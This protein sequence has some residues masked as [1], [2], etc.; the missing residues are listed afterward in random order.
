M[1]MT[2]E[3]KNSSF[4]TLCLVIVASALILFVVAGTI[5]A[6]ASGKAHPGSGLLGAKTRTE[7][8]L[9]AGGKKNP[10]KDEVLADNSGSKAGIFADIGTLRAGTA[11]KKPVTVIILPFFPYPPD[12]IAFREELVSKT[13]AMRSSIQNWFHSRTIKE[14]S[15]IGEAG[16]K[17]E[18]IKCI[19]A[20]LVLG[21]ITTIYFDEYMVLE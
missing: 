20:N 3:R 10:S 21:Q 8:S 4:L 17:A 15:K 7:R 14:I 19:N 1:Q 16:V 11:D 6:F 9:F 2:D 5:W 12:D 18:L 13:R